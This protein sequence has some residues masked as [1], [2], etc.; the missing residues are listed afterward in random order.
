[1]H[2]WGRVTM[3]I[4]ILAVG[5]ATFRRQGAADTEQLLIEAG[6][7]RLPAATANVAPSTPHALVSQHRD[8]RTVY[9]YADPD[10]CTCVYVGG[11]QEYAAYQHLAQDERNAREQALGAGRTEAP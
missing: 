7:T 3:G 9:V 5:C 8:G 4:V 11:R 2:G 6:F 1:M 10:T